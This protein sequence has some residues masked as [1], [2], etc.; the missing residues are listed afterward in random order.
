[1][2]S[3]CERMD[4]VSV[5]DYR[6]GTEKM[7]TVFRA[8]SYLRALLEVE[9]TLAEVQEEKNIIP[10]GASTII[11]KGISSVKRERVEEIE[12]LI[13]HDVMAVVKA[14]EEH[15]GDAGKWIH[16][17]AMMSHLLKFPLSVRPVGPEKHSPSTV[18]Q[19]WRAY[20]TKFPHFRN[21]LFAYRHAPF[22]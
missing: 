17:G 1:M 19:C 4:P 18:S 9:A 12:S 11:R 22:V 10:K 2:G 15:T 6:Y 7:R 13:N 3:F 8:N 5:L 21:R 14:L 20:C 16:F